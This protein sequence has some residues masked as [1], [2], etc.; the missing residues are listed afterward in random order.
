MWFLLQ[1]LISFSH[2]SCD[3]VSLISFLTKKP[4]LR[5][6]QSLALGRTVDQVSKGESTLLPFTIYDKSVPAMLQC[7]IAFL[8]WG[9]W[10]YKSLRRVHKRMVVRWH[11][12][13]ISSITTIKTHRA[14]RIEKPKS[15]EPHTPVDGNKPPSCVRTCTVP[16]SA[17]EEAAGSE[18]VS[19]A[20]RQRYSLK[21]PAEPRGACLLHKA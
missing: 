3:V 2:P 18:G 5:G 7:L 17:H 15:H 6:F 14:A 20:L 10:G 11:E 12:L 8:I 1:W 16:A 19:W 4:R 21:P 13:L 9:G